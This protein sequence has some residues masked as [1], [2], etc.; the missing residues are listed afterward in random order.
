[1]EILVLDIFLLLRRI[2]EDFNDFSINI[3][4]FKDFL[5]KLSDILN[6]LEDTLMSSVLDRLLN[7]FRFDAK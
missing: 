4:L 1:M 7:D 5:V 6:K 2:L 3:L